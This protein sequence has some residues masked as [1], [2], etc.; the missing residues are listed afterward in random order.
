MLLVHDVKNNTVSI[1]TD[2][3]DH[4]C[5]IAIDSYVLDIISESKCVAN[6]VTEDILE[7]DSVNESPL[8]LYHIDKL[9]DII[10]NLALSRI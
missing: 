3:M 4:L 1:T 7:L 9:N 2:N 5:N 8:L 10:K 6:T